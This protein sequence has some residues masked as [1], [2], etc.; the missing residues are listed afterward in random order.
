MFSLKILYAPRSW[1]LHLPSEGLENRKQEPLLFW[2]ALGR[3]QGQGGSGLGSAEG[4]SGQSPEAVT[5]RKQP[6]PKADV[7]VTASPQPMSGV[8][9]QWD[10]PTDSRGRVWGILLS[11][12]IETARR[13]FKRTKGEGKELW[14]Q[15]G[16]G[17][18]RTL[19]HL[20]VSFQSSSSLCCAQKQRQSRG[21]HP[22][23]VCEVMF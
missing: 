1:T 6:L 7:E 13:L 22:D 18:L 15:P 5:N 9:P 23:E 8:Q 2:G 19:S 16:R 20:I 17:Q 11:R 14:P 4:W 21:R 12:G 3:R 10:V